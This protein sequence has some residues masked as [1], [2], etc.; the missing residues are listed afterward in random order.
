[1]IIIPYVLAVLAGLIAGWVT[2]VLAE[3]F[4]IADR[5]LFGPLR[6]VRS[7]EKLAVRDYLPVIGYLLQKGRCRHC[8]KT[9]PWRFPVVEVAMALA[10]AFAW[11]LYEDHDLF[12]Y[13]INLFYIFL[14]AT[15]GLIDW[16]FRLIFP[17][18][19]WTGSLFAIIVALVS[20]M[21]KDNLLLPDNLNSV[22]LGIAIDGGIFLLIYWVAKGIYRKRALGF[23]DVLLAIL[24]GA[25]LGYPRAISALFLGAVL[26][27]V[28][29]I[30][31]FLFGG[32]RWRDFIPYG[33]TMCIGVILILIWGQSVWNWGPFEVVVL[34]MRI[35]YRTIF[36]WFGM[37]T[38]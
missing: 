2:N 16:R 31:F 3:R 12:I 14:L 10:F 38:D 4:P 7:G 28:V 5:P 33:T 15:I 6:C 17:I 13:I 36:G 20:N 30:A 32:K 26:G 35:I 19:I 9:L 27:G 37:Q 18:M 22:L 34:L 11:P 29:A 21:P 25:L 24:I 8:G 23:G 1:V